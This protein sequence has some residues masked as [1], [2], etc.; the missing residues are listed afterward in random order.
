MV[1]QIHKRKTASMIRQEPEG[2]APTRLLSISS[3]CASVATQG[4]VAPADLA[5]AAIRAFQEAALPR[6][7]RENKS[8]FPRY[9]TLGAATIAV[10]QPVVTGG[11]KTAL[12]GDALAVAA[13][14]TVN[15]TDPDKQL[16]KPRMFGGACTSIPNV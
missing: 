2:N 4:K 5:A 6:A 12:T 1:R 14:A 8:G 9:E 10:A 16:G 13:A 11:D 15:A 7:R 3:T